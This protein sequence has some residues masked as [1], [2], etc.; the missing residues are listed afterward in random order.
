M[1]R[2]FIDKQTIVDGVVVIEGELFRHLVTVLRLK[3]GARVTL[4][5]G[6]GG[7]YLGV[8]VSQEGARVFVR[9]EETLATAASGAILPITLFQGIPKGE[10]M[11][12]IL[13]KGT[14]LGAAG[15][16]PFLSS[17]TIPR[18]SGDKAVAR[19]RRWERIVMEAA[20]QSRRPDIPEV[21]TIVTL[22]EALATA[23]QEV[24]LLLWEGESE[25]GLKEVLAAAPN[26][27]VSVALLVGPEGG[28]SREEAGEA[29]AAGFIPVTLGPRI[30]RTET[31][32]LA[33]L[34]ILQYVWGDVG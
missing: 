18:L 23:R 24:R 4:A 25:Q 29:M 31:A 21:G 26:A 14:E 19:V 17:R 15:F 27:A 3:V 28:L 5:D 13:Q 20:R 6:D 32:G 22:T 2:F 9:L 33:V 34:S 8:L 11:E 16:V 1:R 12:M 30:L 7:E 10:R